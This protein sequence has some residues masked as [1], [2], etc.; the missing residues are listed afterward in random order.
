MHKLIKPHARHSGL[1]PESSDFKGNDTGYR[2]S[3]V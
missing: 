1:D 2:L 3:P